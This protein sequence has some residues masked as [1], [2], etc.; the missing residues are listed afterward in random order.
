MSVETAQPRMSPAEQAQLERYFLHK[1]LP[2]LAVG[3]DPRTDTLT[4]MRPGLYVLFIVGLGIALRPDWTWWLRVLAALAV[5][6]GVYALLNLLR[7]RPLLARSRRISFTE[8]V[9]LVALELATGWPTRLG[10]GRHAR[11]H[12]RRRSAH[13]RETQIAA[14]RL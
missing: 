13:S 12:Q 2:H 1:G 5:A 11:S 7:D 10:F 9:A 8:V 6:V 14:C 3:Y 4:R